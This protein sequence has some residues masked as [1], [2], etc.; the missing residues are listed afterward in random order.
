MPIKRILYV[1]LVIVVA[2]ASALTGAFAGGVVVYRT[3]QKPSTDLPGPIQDLLLQDDTSPGQTITLNTTD[4]QT[5][6]TKAV[7][8]VGP[9]VVTVVG[10]I[11][12]GTTIFG[13]TGDQLV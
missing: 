7:Q 8:K 2:G 13:S 1:L 4:I 11:P 12:G 3:L 9:A 6:I 10:T 5:D